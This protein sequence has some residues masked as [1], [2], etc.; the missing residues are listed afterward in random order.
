M[1]DAVHCETGFLCRVEE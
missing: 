1:F